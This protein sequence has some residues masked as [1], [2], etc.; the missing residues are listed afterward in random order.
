MQVGY[1]TSKNYKG[2][3]DMVN[4]GVDVFSYI[5]SKAN[6]DGGEGDI[7]TIYKCDDTLYARDNGVIF[8]THKIEEGK[9]KFIELCNEYVVEFI[10]PSMG[11]KK[12]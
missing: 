3:W 11:V 2:L 10:P 12:V 4:S 6:E 1:Q 7:C 5:N 8:F 9:D